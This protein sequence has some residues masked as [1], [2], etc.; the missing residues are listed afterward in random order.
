[1]TTFD[2]DTEQLERIN[3]LRERLHRA[4]SNA[5]DLAFE[6]HETRLAMLNAQ[7][8]NAI[9]TFLERKG[10]THKQTTT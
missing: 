4:E 8:I 5:A 1:M 10:L 9:N 2:N 7:D 3:A 6:L